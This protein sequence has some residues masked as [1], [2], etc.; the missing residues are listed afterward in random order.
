M[1]IKYMTSVNIPEYTSRND[2]KRWEYTEPI[3]T[4]GNGN[5]VMI[6]VTAREI[7]ACIS[8]SN[9]GV[10]SVQASIN[11]VA[12]VLADNNV[13]WTEWDIGEVAQNAEDTTSPVTAIRGVNVAGIVQLILL[14]YD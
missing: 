13:T 12:D 2:N 6:P 8:M 14:A 5:A 1:A 3:S 9:G 7:T 11:S 10:G 4:P